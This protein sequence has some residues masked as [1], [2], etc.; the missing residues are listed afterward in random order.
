MES[1]APGKERRAGV[2]LISEGLRLGNCPQWF[3]KEESPAGMNDPAGG[4]DGCTV[5]LR[6]SSSRQPSGL[7]EP[8]G[9]F[10][11]GATRGELGSIISGS[12][13]LDGNT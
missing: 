10:R 5:G 2:A 11:R 6:P 3:R 9:R 7:P 4:E 8:A 13:E 1:G 12:V